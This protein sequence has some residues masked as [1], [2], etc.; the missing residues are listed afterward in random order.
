MHD[1]GRGKY[2]HSSIIDGGQRQYVAI[3]KQGNRGQI[4]VVS[5]IIGHTTLHTNIQ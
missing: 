1:T 2:R 5:A 4:I 3:I